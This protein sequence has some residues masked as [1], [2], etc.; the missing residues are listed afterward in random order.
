MEPQLQ[1]APIPP[2]AALP[3]PRRLLLVAVLLPAIV[4]GT[5]QLLV[6]TLSNDTLRTWFF[7]SLV[8][9]TGAISWC[10][11]RYLHPF[12]F[13]AIFF[14]WCLVLLDFLIM[15]AR[16][17]HRIED[18][19]GYVL[20]SA[21]V[22]LLVLWA[23]LGPQRWQW[24]LPAVAA[25]VPLVVFLADGFALAYGSRQDTSWNVMMFIT[26]SIAAILC[27]G[28]RYFGFTL[29]DTSRSHAGGPGKRPSY[30]FGMKH[31]LIWFTVS[32]PLLLLVRSFD[33][34][35]TAVFPAALLSVTVATVNLIAIWAVLGSGHW[36]I[37]AL[38]LIGIPG[39]LAIGMSYYSAHIKSTFTAWSPGNYGSITWVIG[40]MQDHWFAWLWLDAALLA[41]LLLFF[42][43]SGYRLS[44]N[45]Q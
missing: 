23:V 31:M 21:Q 1:N 29:Q 27:G 35:G 32:G 25:L 43:A 18:E 2:A 8:L 13:Q 45:A 12:W 37:R 20:V 44:R 17:T 39:L 15:V 34:E 41:A 7:P 24:R 26:A 19:F 4:A 16:L 6:E 30:Q 36:S 33:F 14:A 5:N 10:A 40:Q 9:S 11:G 22:S 28:L 38:S 3:S 42:R